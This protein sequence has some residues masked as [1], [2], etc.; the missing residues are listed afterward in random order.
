MP[1]PDL[2]PATPAELITHLSLAI[3]QSGKRKRVT[4]VDETAAKLVAEYLVSELVAS[5]W[6]FLRSRSHLGH[7]THPPK[8]R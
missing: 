5:G 2:I 1:E 4:V 7:S 8:S 3:S 6:T